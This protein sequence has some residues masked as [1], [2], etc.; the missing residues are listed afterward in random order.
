MDVTMPKFSKKRF[1]QDKQDKIIADIKKHILVF[2]TA[3]KDNIDNHK[4][5][6]KFI[7]GDQWEEDVVRL[8]KGSN[9]MMLT[10]N[11]IRPFMKQ[12]LAD[13]SKYEVDMM[14]RNVGANADDT[15]QQMQQQD[16]EDIYTGLL[17]NIAY[18]SQTQ[19]IYNTSY[20]DALE[21]GYGAWRVVVEK[22]KARNEL[23]I[24]RVNNPLTCYWDLEALHECKT[25]GEYCGVLT[26][27]SK[28]E[29]ERRYP[30]FDYPDP[31]SFSSF[32][33]T[34]VEWGTDKKIAICEEYRREYYK[35]KQYT[36]K[37][38][39][40]LDEEDFENA[41]IPE[42]LVKKSETIN[43]SR[44]VHYKV[45]DHYLLEKSETPFKD[46]PLLFVG[47]YVR[48]IDGR[49]TTYS[50]AWDAKD[51]QRQLNYLG[52]D[53]AQWMKMYKKTKFMSPAASISKYI[54]QWTNPD[55]PDAVLPYDP[56]AGDGFKPEPIQQPTMPPDIFEQ[57]QRAE[58]D[59][60][61][62]LGRY[63]PNIGAQSNEQSGIAIYNRALQGNTAPDEARNHRNAAI[64]ETGRIILNAIPGV[65]DDTR[66]VTITNAAGED[67]TVGINQP[68]FNPQTATN[69]I[70]STFG[71]NDYAVEIDVGPTF[72]M[73][74]AST[75]QFLIQLVSAIP[76]AAPLLGEFIAE[77]VDVQHADKIASRLRTLVP[78]QILLQEANPQPEEV[79]LQ[80]MMQAQQQQ[81]QQEA[82]MA[83]L[84]QQMQQ[85]QMQAGQLANQAQQIANLKTQQDI[86][87][88]HLKTTTDAKTKTMDAETNRM[89]MHQQG[90]VQAARTQA[91]LIKS[92]QETEQKKLEMA[93]TAMGV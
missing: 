81:Q 68:V 45:T 59:I 66:N 27:I 43:C 44:I 2:R 52:S 19:N 15:T 39:T 41:K 14:L 90:I 71:E 83:Q 61:R 65:Y 34:K 4:M 88:N 74:K 79:M 86:I 11:K 32:T 18:K 70:E 80:Q 84:Q 38:G 20:K 31:G 16:K 10:F 42:R 72:P 67:K 50:F 5:M 53:I 87:N 91:E 75:A 49:E 89:E 47:G 62:A 92:Q 3:Y 55:H 21:G 60:Q 37:D 28:E 29:F 26:Y 64:A 22:N 30:N 85:I 7:N 25:D 77:S 51:P 35:E 93:K 46:L 33:E 36:L 1:S 73:Q 76:Q 63:E 13:D 69:E 8:Y 9:R 12:M 56:A 24:R 78:P 58:N 48:D 82:Q 57:Y 17:R 40:I 23:R 6:T 54:K